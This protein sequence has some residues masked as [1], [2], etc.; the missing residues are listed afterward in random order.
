VYVPLFNILF[1]LLHSNFVGSQCA[2]LLLVAIRMVFYV[3]FD[4]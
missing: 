4:I 1:G 3:H 2:M